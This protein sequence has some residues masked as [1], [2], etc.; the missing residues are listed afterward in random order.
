M[1]SITHLALFAVGPALISSAF[2]NTPERTATLGGKYTVAMYGG[3]LGLNANLSHR[4]E[5]QIFELPS[6]LDYGGYTLFNAG[7]TWYS[8]TTCADEGNSNIWT[9]QNQF[10]TQRKLGQRTMSLDMEKHMT[11]RQFP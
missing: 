1:K 5:T 9:I 10:E 7:A 2:A 3:E 8:R 6:M 4:S 11:R